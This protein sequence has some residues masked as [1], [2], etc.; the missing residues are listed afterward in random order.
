MVS[1]ANFLT[2]A[3]LLAYSGSVTSATPANVLQGNIVKPRDAVFRDAV[4][5]HV[6]PM[7]SHALD[8]PQEPQALRR[9]GNK[10]GNLPANLT[11]VHDI[12]YIIDLLV[13]NQT[14][15]VSVD[16]GSSDTWF[17]Q[18]P[19]QCVSYFWDEGRKPDC[20]LGDGFKGNL[21][22]GNI[23]DVLFGRAYTDG[24]FVQ[25]YFGYEDVTIGGLTAH[26]QTLAI[27]NLTYWYGDG[28]V[29]GLLGLG[30][31]YM[32]SLSGAMDSQPEYDPVFTTIWKS[33]P[34]APIFSI[35]LSRDDNV[36]ATA[37]HPKDETSFLALGGLP[38]VKYDDASWG[39]TPIQP[40]SAMI[41]SWGIDSA[42]HGLYII[43][44]DAYVYG[45]TDNVTGE[46]VGELTRNTTQFPILIDAGST[47]SVI[48]K[49]MCEAIYAAF[50]PPAQYL[51]STGL[52]YAPCNATVPKFGV[53][54]GGK[55][56]YIA[57]QD[58]LR[59]NAR[60]HTGEF[61]RVGVTDS[62]S[63]PHVLGVTFLS[64]VVAVFD[65]GNHEMRFAA[66][67]AY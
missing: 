44:A 67:N 19:Y 7:R 33:N 61:C 31:P 2:R 39:R 32:T 48:P 25:G 28:R 45:R 12:Y 43:S 23:P 56:F 24:T 55:T 52:F 36:N 26:H 60:D 65:V 46:V 5:T 54:I 4:T 1:V 50:D 18:Q 20:G 58:L 30:Y 37:G 53:Q 17:V 64:N 11:N 16:T 10:R 38:P 21:S 66:R 41:S 35:A 13:G 15:P 3:I 59:Q 40:I 57:P 51:S 29:S 63:P 8:H 9:R 6:V 42:E 47:L 27:V 14:I 34:I 62:D 49:K 22:G